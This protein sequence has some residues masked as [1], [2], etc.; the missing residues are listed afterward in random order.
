MPRVLL[1]RDVELAVLRSRLDEVRAGAGRIV[2]VE[3][4]A[5]IGKSAL[6]AEAARGAG[7]TGMRVLRAWCGPLDQDA[8]WGVARQLMS[9]VWGGP[10]WDELTAGAAGLAR[11][12]LVPDDPAP[13]RAVP[14]PAR[15]RDAGAPVAV[16]DAA[17]AAAHGL[18]WLVSNVADRCPTLLV[19]DDAQWADAPSLRWLVRLSRQLSEMPLGVLCAVRSGEPPPEPDLLAELLAAAPQAPVR[20]APLR[21][22]AVA[23]LVRER[24]PDAAAAFPGACHAATAGNPFLLG[25]LIDHLLSERIAPTD[26][27]A[28]RLSTFGPDQ[29]VRTL[30]RQLARLPAGATSLALALAVLGPAAPLRRVA[31]LAD[32]PLDTAATLADRLCAAGLLRATDGGYALV[33][34]LIAGAL[35]QGLPAG[36]RA[37]RHARAAALLAGERVDPETVALHLLR[38]EPA[39]DPATVTALRD[40]ARRATA[41]GAPE[42][43]AAFLRRALAEPPPDRATEAEL[44]S[45]LG[46]AM[47]AQLHPDAPRRLRR[48]VGLAEVEQRARIALSGARALGLAGHFPDAIDVC[49]RG[50]AEPDGVPAG[51]LARLEAELVC[52]A[53]L[54]ESTTAEARQRLRDPIVPRDTSPLWRVNAAWE[55][56]TRAEPAQRM[57]SLLDPVLSSGALDAEL[58]SLL[59]SMMKYSLIAGGRLDI[60]EQQCDAL[61]DAARPRGWLIALAHGSFLRAIAHVHAGRIQDAATDAR[62]SFD[63]KL[64]VSPPA[65]LIWSLFPLVDAL[66][67]LGDLAGADAALAAA[68]QLGEPADALAGPMLLESRARLRRAQ[69]RADDA[70]ADLRAAAERWDR[71]GVV[72]PGV[73]GWRVEIAA[74]LVESGDSAGARRYAEEHLALAERVGLPAPRAGGLRA[75]ALTADRDEAV[76][77]LRR[78]VAL[79]DRSPFRLEHVRS[80]VELGAALRR[81]N[82]RAAAGEHLRH[83]LDL[84]A[85][86][87]M[88]R[89]AERARRELHVLGARPRRNA[90]RG[91]EALTPAEHR[92]A[93]LAARGQSNRDIAQQLYVTRRTVETHLTHVFQK[94]GIASRAELARDLLTAAARSH[95]P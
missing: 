33:H 16:G 68:G 43:A 32:L 31:A 49:R 22:D 19:V 27:V 34:P 25:S 65:A 52:D 75:R 66:T 47:A 73:A 2:V 23:T 64:S 79:V 61:I 46:L 92:V 14:D 26:D 80:L 29:V 9:P 24:L 39:G 21:E 86:G 78:A 76:T 36:E 30:R 28:G 12:A 10:D 44:C 62:L 51:L 93:L 4:P 91:V 17:H 40:A 45:E 42:S 94:L 35:Y 60:A 63:H 8:G 72:H 90:I 67:E 95:R 50:L 70:V 5:G 1:Q 15:P 18:T 55:A 58:D 53:Y 6:V 11:R 77:L 71:L 81:A 3:G 48:A 82:R 41:R 38:G 59:G 57:L 84:A 83:A 7:A 89:L 37:R 85:R 56:V 74:V 69:G 88:R 54:L 20:P 13:D 87:G